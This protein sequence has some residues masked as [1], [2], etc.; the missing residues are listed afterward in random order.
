MADL[1]FLR[2]NQNPAAQQAARQILLV[3]YYYARMYIH[4]I[5]VQALVDRV[6]NLGSGEGIWQEHEMLRSKYA[7]DYAS[8]NEVRESSGKILTIAVELS[9]QGILQYCP[10]RLFLR[11]VSASV[12]LLKAI[13][14]GCREADISASLKTLD[15]CIVA[16]QTDRADD[17]HLS[18][19]Y[20][21]LMA[22]HVQRFK[23]NFRGQKSASVYLARPL[24]RSR[25]AS[26]IA[27]NGAK[28]NPNQHNL[29]E[30]QDGQLYTS[31]SGTSEAQNGGRRL[32]LEQ[33][34][35]SLPNEFNFGEDE[36]VEDWLAQPFDPQMAPFGLDF[37]QPGAEL[38]LDSLD[39]LWNIES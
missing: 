38:A 22:R 29:Q 19:Q 16:L 24:Y 32:D 39:F 21:S 15:Q 31:G 37:M 14:L 5:A 33:T 11:I 23:R 12:F 26:P 9:G 34:Y 28:A 18:T 13:S 6:S 30:T 1:L 25:A 35:T 10:V 2:A 36:T 8:V 4:S 20:A 27:S 17:I 7:Q 3:D